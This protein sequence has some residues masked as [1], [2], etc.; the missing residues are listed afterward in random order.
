MSFTGTTDLA[1]RPS[2]QALRRA[3]LR[4]DRIGVDIV[5]REAVFR[6]DQIGRDALRQEVGG[7]GDARIDRPCAARRAHADAAHGFDA[8][9]DGD[10]LH[11]RH[12]LRGGEVHGVEAR[13][14]EAVDLHARHLLAEA[15]LQRRGARDVAAR[16]ADRIDAAEHHVLDQLRDRDRCACGSHR[17]SSRRG[18]TAGTSCSEPSGLPRP[19][20]VRT[21]S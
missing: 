12:H 15:G 2:S 17:A 9:A 3:L 6:R 16:L 10:V 8:A 19:R 20:G 7:D 18:R 1:K 11:A 14:A 4:L 5:A 21:A 13:G